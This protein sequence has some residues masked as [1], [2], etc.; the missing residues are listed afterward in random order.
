[1]HASD[2]MARSA[3]SVRCPCDLGSGMIVRCHLCLGKNGNPTL[4][5]VSRWQFL[6]ITGQSTSRRP[7]SRYTSRQFSHSSSA[8]TTTPQLT[9]P[10]RSPLTFCQI[11]AVIVSPTN[12]GAAQNFNSSVR[13]ATGEYFMWLAADDRIRPEFIETCVREHRAHPEAPACLSRH[14]VHRLS[15]LPDA[16]PD[17]IVP[18]IK[19]SQSAAALV[20]ATP[21]L[22][23][24]VFAV[25]SREPA[26]VSSVH[27]GVRR[28]RDADVGGSSYAA[29]SLL[30]AKCS[31]S[32][33]SIR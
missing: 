17:R 23:R 12:V 21:A 18:R 20:P 32:I 30:P 8:C 27:H 33:A 3:P 10:C 26:G 1:M 7:S 16:C 15:R 14:S 29:R 22:D 5:H 11:G 13:G 4:P 25:P 2:C 31:S 24:D 9:R 28:G 19:R 6:S